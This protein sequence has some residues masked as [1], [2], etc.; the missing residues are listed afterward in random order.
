VEQPEPHGGDGLN[1]LALALL[2]LLA[3]ALPLVLLWLVW[4]PLSV[5]AGVLMVWYL[6]ALRLPKGKP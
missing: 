3:L 1:P 2:G 5:G 6:A 4:P